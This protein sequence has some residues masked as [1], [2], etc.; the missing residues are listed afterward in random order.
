MKKINLS[1]CIVL[2]FAF[3]NITYSATQV[4]SKFRNTTEFPVKLQSFHDQEINP[5]ETKIIAPHELYISNI[6]GNSTVRY[7]I[8]PN[9]SAQRLNMSF[10]S[11]NIVY[12]VSTNRFTLQAASLHRKNSQDSYLSDTSVM[13]IFNATTFPIT[14]SV[15]LKDAGQIIPNLIPDPVKN[16]ILTPDPIPAQAFKQTKLPIGGSYSTDDPITSVTISCAVKK[17]VSHDLPVAV[18]KNQ[19]DIVHEFGKIKI[20]SK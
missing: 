19:Y 1:L 11:K 17:Y 18:I 6:Q 20:Q 8:A 5:S 13:Q 12:D 7:A 15:V 10:G 2:I 3:N 9:I 4:T 14:I 16:N